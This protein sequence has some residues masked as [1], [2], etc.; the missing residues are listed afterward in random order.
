MAPAPLTATERLTTRLWL[1]PQDEQG[2]VVARWF[3]VGHGCHDGG[4]GGF[5]RLG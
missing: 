1:P 5:G 2:D 3:V 4:R